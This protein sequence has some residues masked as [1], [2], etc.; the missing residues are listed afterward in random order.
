MARPEKISD[1]PMDERNE[2]IGSFDVGKISVNPG[3]LEFYAKLIR[4]IEKAGGSVERGEYAEQ[5]V[6]LYLPKDQVQLEKKL[7]NMQG[8]WD[9]NK[10][11]Y[12]SAVTRDETGTEFDEWDRNRIVEFAEKEG[13]P[14]PFDVFAANDDEL[15]EIRKELES[16]KA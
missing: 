6:R 7:K 8:S 13:L 16:N 14:N 12:D 9:Y 11:K 5:S 2:E 4:E 15:N 3:L 10:K 1:I